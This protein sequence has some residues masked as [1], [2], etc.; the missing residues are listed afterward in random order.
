MVGGSKGAGE[1]AMV[2]DG[3][4]TMTAAVLATAVVMQEGHTAG[5]LFP[6]RGGGWGWVMADRYKCHESG[7][8]LYYR[9][10]DRY[11]MN[12]RMC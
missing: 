2:G 12:Q 7:G 10:T 6:V 8:W 5:A 3:L 9:Q 4:A 1:G 11:I